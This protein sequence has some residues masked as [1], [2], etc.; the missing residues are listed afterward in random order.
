M[1]NRLTRKERDYRVK[2]AEVLTAAERVFAQKG[3]ADTFMTDI[4]AEAQLSVGTLYKFFA[5]KEALYLA[6]IEEYF[7][8]FLLLLQRAI[9]AHPDPVKDLEVVVK[10]HLDY[11]EQHKDFFLI[12]INDCL[13]LE[14]R[15]KERLGENIYQLH[16]QYLAL[17]TTIMEQ[18][19]K[20]G[21]LKPLPPQDLAHILISMVNS[22][23]FQWLYTDQT[24]PLHTKL[25]V[26]LDVFFTGACRHNTSTKRT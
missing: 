21:V 25:P 4:A 14:W 24:S 9:S 12:Y 23:I 8:Q 6:L 19:K 7:Q 13:A 10:A 11:F 15:I 16:L 17:V 26:I 22:L 2:R 3:F 5:S 18:G 20:K 1:L